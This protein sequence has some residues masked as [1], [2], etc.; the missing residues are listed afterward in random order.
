MKKESPRR[1]RVL[2]ALVNNPGLK[3]L[4]LLAAIFI[5]LYVHNIAIFIPSRGI[6]LRPIYQRFVNPNR[7]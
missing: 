5:W 7:R 4:A 1:H 2:A 3:I 6:T